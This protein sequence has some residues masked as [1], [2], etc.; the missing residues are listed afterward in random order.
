MVSFRWRTD[1][2]PHWSTHDYRRQRMIY[3][4]HKG[5]HRFLPTIWGGTIARKIRRKVMFLPS[6][7]Y[8]IGKD[9]G[10]WNK[11]IGRANLSWKFWRGVH[12][13]SYRLCAR[14]N[15]V[16]MKVEIAAYWYIG[17]KRHVQQFATCRINELVQD[18]SIERVGKNTIFRC[19][20]YSLRVEGPWSWVGS[21]LGPFFGGNKSAPHP[22]ELYM[23]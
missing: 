17:G 19:G 6:W 9:Q 11:I 7:K 15:P 14:Y 20:I 23:D 18:F 8:D 16:D 5:K 21:K 22:M 2:S 10:D 1:R 3:K 13:E 12:W 4:C